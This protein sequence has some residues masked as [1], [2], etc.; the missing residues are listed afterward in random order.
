[1]RK[2][3]LRREARRGVFRRLRGGEGIVWEG[4]PIP[5]PTPSRSIRFYLTAAATTPATSSPEKK[6]NNPRT[7]TD[8]PPFLPFPPF[9]LRDFYN[10]QHRRK[11]KLSF[12]LLHFRRRSF[13]ASKLEIFLQERSGQQRRKGSASSGLGDDGGGREMYLVVYNAGMTIASVLAPPASS[14]PS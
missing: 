1:M 5:G 12:G 9:L 4:S 2:P 6:K 10:H 8:R 13:E 3:R 14:S 7:Q 11:I